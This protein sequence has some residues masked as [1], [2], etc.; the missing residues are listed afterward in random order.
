MAVAHLVQSSDPGLLRVLAKYCTVKYA[1][2]SPR[3]RKFTIRM[4]LQRWRHE[5]LREFLLEALRYVVVDSS[6]I[7][8]VDQN[9]ITWEFF[10]D[11]L[12][13]GRHPLWV[14]RL[15]RMHGWGDRV[16]ELLQ[17]LSPNAERVYRAQLDISRLKL[18][19]IVYGDQIEP[20]G[21]APPRPHRASLERQLRSRDTQLRSLTSDREQAER[22]RQA[23]RGALTRTEKELSELVK[24]SRREVEE[25]DRDL[26]RRRR[27][28]RRELAEAEVR[29]RERV[30]ALERRLA[31]IQ[32]EHAEVLKG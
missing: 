31:E 23:M 30:K 19:E 12:Y 17:E 1:G 24:Q 14:A 22:S 27:Q 5:R 8:L 15:L 18:R 28:Q 11:L 2:S 7:S 4:I 3:A 16:P 29:H 25:A 21:E 9:L 13:Q 10:L 20:A 6:G 26:N 32:K